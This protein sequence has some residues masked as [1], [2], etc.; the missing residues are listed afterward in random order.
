MA[1]AVAGLILAAVQVYYARQQVKGGRS[2]KQAMSQ[3]PRSE[4]LRE[5]RRYKATWA[6]VLLTP[7]VFAVLLIV[8][9]VIIYLFG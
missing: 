3:E 2:P 5:R 8:V 4:V 6:M 9:G 1:I 7:V